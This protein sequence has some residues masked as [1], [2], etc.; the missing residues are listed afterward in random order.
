MP[1]DRTAPTAAATKTTRTEYLRL[2]NHARQRLQRHAATAYAKGDSIRT[3]A[4]A[5]GYAYATMHRVLTDAGVTL[6]GRGYNHPH[7][8]NH[9][10]PAALPRQE[11]S[12]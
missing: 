2:P 10:T 1:D 4:T 3:I 11:A 8:D 5:T 9:A 12:R 7:R 6:R